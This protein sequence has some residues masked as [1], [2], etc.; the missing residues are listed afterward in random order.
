MNAIII[1]AH[2]IDDRFILNQSKEA[3][4][5]IP[6]LCFWRYRSDLDKGKPKHRELIED[7]GIFIKPRRHTDR[8]GKLN[9]EYRSLKTRIC[10]LI[11]LANP[12]R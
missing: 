6:R 7:F 8:M 3:F 1:K 11:M 4:F 2:T 9:A 5:R 12:L 10:D